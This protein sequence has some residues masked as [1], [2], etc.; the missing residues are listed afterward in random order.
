MRC[1]RM[2]VSCTVVTLLAACHS[3]GGD[4]PPPAG[5][6]TVGGT[7]TGLAG[8]GLVLRLNGGN[9]RQVGANGAFTFATSLANNAAYAVTVQTQPSAPT[10][11]C[12]VGSGTGAI[13][14]ANV[15]NVTVTC[16]TR[17]FL[18]GGT[19]SGLTTQGL[20]LRDVAGTKVAIAAGGTSFQFPAPV[21]SGT[22]YFVTISAQPAGNP[23]E[24]CTVANGG[25]VVGGA[26]VSIQVIC[27]SGAARFLYVPDPV[28]NNVAALRV[29][30]GTG[31]LSAVPGSP[32]ATAPGPQEMAA[33]PS[34]AFFYVLSPAAGAV[35]AFAV[36]QTTG[37]LAA[38][39]GSPFTVVPAG[40]A[41]IPA[42]YLDP[43]GRFL[44]VQQSGTSA[45]F[46]YALH[47]TS[48][49]LTAIP[50]SPFVAPVGSA[51][52]GFD[53][54]ARYA[55]T[56]SGGVGGS[57]AFQLDNVTG[58]LTPVGTPVGTNG[59]NSLPTGVVHP[60]GALL[61]ASFGG[62]PIYTLQVDLAT[63]QLTNAGVVSAGSPRFPRIDPNGRFL[64]VAAGNDVAGY[65][66]AAFTG[67]LLPIQGS[68]FSAGTQ[69]G[70]FDIDRTGGY[71]YAPNA[72]G[73]GLLAG[74][75]IDP[76]TGALT[77]APGLPI[78]FGQNTNPNVARID[79]AGR[80]L[81]VSSS[82]DRK[83]RNYAIGDTGALTPLSAGASVVNVG[84][85]GLLLLGT[86]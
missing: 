12:V 82:G 6:F 43:S 73:E 36:D 30:A 19:V 72:L 54:L 21:L 50:G 45:F 38:V 56:V 1:A 22:P 65:E 69:T 48:G 47:P 60:S 71:L 86:Q 16:T 3:G 81:Y 13:A 63:G 40:N 23:A 57:T 75:A 52:L 64:Y 4:S 17:S 85:R 8:T 46:G 37:A 26:D 20:E 39:P 67:T 25:G 53:P 15:T 14:G 58:A 27:N 51:W 11:D 76:T 7:V 32:F 24:I 55:Y 29:D 10:Q 44:Y 77:S 33:T 18:I 78:A 62:G 35:S 41:A 74:F 42:L 31:V 9:D 66:I 5:T 79:R 59:S 68:P 80:V 61:Y 2:I 49:V 70:D 83:I 28:S 84:A 34:G